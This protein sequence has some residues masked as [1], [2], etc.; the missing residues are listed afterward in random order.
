MVE[1]RY[2]K[3]CFLSTNLFLINLR[4]DKVKHHIAKKAKN[5]KKNIN[6]SSYY[7]ELCIC[8]SNSKQVLTSVR[9]SRE[10]QKV[11]LWFKKIERHVSH[12]FKTMRNKSKTSIEMVFSSLSKLA[13]K[14]Q[15]LFKGFPDK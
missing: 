6:L 3:L 12:E 14:I 11:T 10:M 4:Q 13:D 15:L 5:K 7:M 2:G 1:T 9:A 8:H